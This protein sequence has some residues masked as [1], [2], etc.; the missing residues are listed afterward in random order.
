MRGVPSSASSVVGDCDAFRDPLKIAKLDLQLARSHARSV[1]VE[2]HV[3]H[4]ARARAL[5]TRRG[6]RVEAAYG[7]L[8]EAVVPVTALHALA[9]DDA[10]RFVGEP[11]QPVP[12]DVR[13]QGVAATGAAAWQRA[14]GLGDGVKIAVVDLGFDGYRRSEA[15]GDLPVS[16]VKADF[17]PS[18]GFQAT[19]HGTA[20]AEIVSEMAPAAKLYL[21]CAQSVAGLGLAVQYAHAH[22]IQIISHSVSWLNTSRGDGT[23][24]PDTPEGIVAAARS[25]G[26]LW[27][28]AAGNRAQQ[29]WSGTFVDTNANGWNEFAPGDEGNTIT[30]PPDTSTC[31]ALKWDDWPVSAED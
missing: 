19:S 17:C 16:L 22:G 13:G 3:A 31:I 9:R 28:N 25:E 5:V 24:L 6:G 30:L 2:L 4:P 18:G 23:G 15:N 1:R 21:I 29:H 12:E 27:V 11:A 14:G 26:I 8:V 20:V 10:V 7:D